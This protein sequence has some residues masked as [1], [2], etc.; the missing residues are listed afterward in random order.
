MLRKNVL[1]ALWLGVSILGLSNASA[2]TFQTV[3]ADWSRST[4]GF[5]GTTRSFNDG[6]ALGGVSFVNQVTGIAPGGGNLFKTVGAIQLGSLTAPDTST[7]NTL[8]GTSTTQDVLVAVFALQGSLQDTGV[9]TAP[10]QV[11]FESGTVSF[12]LAKQDTGN[13]LVDFAK[14]NPSTWGTGGT[15]Y[16]QYS[17]KPQEAVSPG[18]GGLVVQFNPNQVNILNGTVELNQLFSGNFLFKETNIGSGLITTTTGSPGFNAEGFLA[19]ISET[20]TVVPLI[21]PATN[22][23]I[24]NTIAANLNYGSFNGFATGF[25]G[26]AVTDYNPILT[27]GDFASTVTL[28]NFAPGREFSTQEVPEPASLAVWGIGMGVAGLIAARRRRMAK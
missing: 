17:L 8:G 19:I 7:F 6:S 23:P 22:L 16:A 14:G 15:L 12:Y 3:T 10:I 13:P 5:G 18:P 11:N 21:D 2:D 28:G 26:A 20:I 9:P 24:L 27:N 4:F 1:V 25:G